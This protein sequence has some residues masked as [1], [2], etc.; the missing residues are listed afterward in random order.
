MTGTAIDRAVVSSPPV[1]TDAFHIEVK[2]GVWLNSNTVSSRWSVTVITAWVT[3]TVKL[4][5]VWS[6]PALVTLTLSLH[7][8]V[9]V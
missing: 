7:I 6:V 1:L 8:S 2:F 5:T 9:S 4:S 3:D